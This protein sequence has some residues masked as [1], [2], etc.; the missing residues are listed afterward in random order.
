MSVIISEHLV[1]CT[2]PSSELDDF[3]LNTMLTCSPALSHLG[4]LTPVS[5][6]R[7]HSASISSDSS[8]GTQDVEMTFPRPDEQMQQMY[9][10]QTSGPPYCS[11]TVAPDMAACGPSEIFSQFE[12]NQWAPMQTY[13]LSPAL[14]SYT[15]SS[16]ASTFPAFDTPS[17]FTP[18]AIPPTPQSISG[19]SF[20]FGTASSVGQQFLSASPALSQRQGPPRRHSHSVPA[21][22]IGASPRMG[23]AQALAHSAPTSDPSSGS[24]TRTTATLTTSSL[25]ASPSTTSLHQYGIP[26]LP[27]ASSST[28]QAWRCA[29]PGCTSRAIFTRGCDLRKHFNRHSKHLFCRVEGCPQSEAE[30]TTNRATSGGF[31]SKK[32]RA[33]HEAKHNPGIRCEWRGPAGEEC[34]RIFSRM[35]NMKDH[36]RRIHKKGARSDHGH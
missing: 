22:S 33:R 35:D 9:L 36:V 32:D 30:A 2:P 25:S 31:S 6:P 3:D 29:Y 34:G 4:C 19:P 23:Q 7:S 26:V 24:L 27:E 8:F 16:L 11:L 13:A 15:T 28:N 14:S 1:S 17:M 21:L 10:T 5:L 12:N 18:A 20:N